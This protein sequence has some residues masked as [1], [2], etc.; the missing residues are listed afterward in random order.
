MR[1]FEMASSWLICHLRHIEGFKIKLKGCSKGEREIKICCIEVSRAL[2]IRTKS[3]LKLVPLN[4]NSTT[5]SGTSRKRPPL[6][7]GLGGRLR[8]VSLTLTDG[9]TNRDFG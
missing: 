2:Q 4:K 1:A 3:I 8:E 6:M 5:Y 9:G 7:S